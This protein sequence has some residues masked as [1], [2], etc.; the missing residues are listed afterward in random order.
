MI[1]YLWMLQCCS[2]NLPYKTIEKDWN[3]N[4]TGFN[5]FFKLQKV[6]SSVVSTRILSQVRLFL[7]KLPS[8]TWWGWLAPHLYGMRLDNHMMHF[9]KSQ[10]LFFFLN[11]FWTYFTLL[12]LVFYNKLLEPDRHFALAM[13]SDVFDSFVA[14]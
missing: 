6:S 14:N 12:L 9:M 10:L 1:L 5:M 7:T 2:M 4:E 11:D 3:Q 8:N 13:D